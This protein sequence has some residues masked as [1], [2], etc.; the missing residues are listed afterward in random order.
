MAEYRHPLF[1]TDNDF[2]DAILN[3]GFEASDPIQVIKDLLKAYHELA[4]EFAN[5]RAMYGPESPKWISNRVPR[6]KLK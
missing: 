1:D 2:R 5:Y 4:K 6:R 3:A